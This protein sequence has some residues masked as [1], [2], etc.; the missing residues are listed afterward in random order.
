MTAKVRL[1]IAWAGERFNRNYSMAAKKFGISKSNISQTLKR[2]RIKN[3]KQ[4][5]E[6][7][8]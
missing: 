3:A 4:R 8:I 7:K 6:N 5:A 2:D 1:A